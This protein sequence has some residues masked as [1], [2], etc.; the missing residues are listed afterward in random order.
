LFGPRIACSIGALDLKKIWHPVTFNWGRRCAGALRK[1]VIVNSQ[2]SVV[3]G[4]SIDDLG[5]VVDRLQ[6]SRGSSRF[7]ER[8]KRAALDIW[9][10]E[11]H[12]AV[13]ARAGYM[14]N[15]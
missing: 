13:A 2:D 1:A 7:T 5:N 11:E 8:R 4:A 3:D 6:N 15:D 14:S 9:K 10:H 12:T